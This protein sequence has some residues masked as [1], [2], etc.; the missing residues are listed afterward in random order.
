ML[1]AFVLVVC[2]AILLWRDPIARRLGIVDLP[3]RDR[4]LHARPTPL[5]GGPVFIVAYLACV[6]TIYFRMDDQEQALYAITAIVLPHAML[7]LIDDRLRLPTDARLLFSVSLTAAALLADRSLVI[8]TVYFSFGGDLG[9]VPIRLQSHFAFFLTL[10]LIVGTVYSVNLIDGKNGV[11]GVYFLST[12]LFAGIWLHGGNGSL[13]LAAIA[14]ILLFL[15]WNLRGLVFAGDSGAYL[16]GALVASTILLIH[17]EQA[18]AMT[19]P[20]ELIGLVVF[21]PAV[22]AARMLA[23]RLMR[24]QNPFAGD[25]DHFHHLLWRRFGPVGGL[26]AFGATVAVPLAAA[27]VFPRHA[28][29][30]LLVAAVLYGSLVLVCHRHDLRTVST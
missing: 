20:I 28:W 18:T 13:L 11:L 25:S 15:V 14:A 1:V 29:A 21:V 24:A 3:D 5:V 30:A 7:G 26:L 2:T 4:K 10:M 16:V 12:T 6:A 27:V 17:R 8:R 9:L 19:F 23:R 22:D